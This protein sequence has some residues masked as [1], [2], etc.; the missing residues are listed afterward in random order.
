MGKPHNK[1]LRDIS[2]S[3]L[4]VI[5][6]SNGKTKT[7]VVGGRFQ[8]A[9]MTNANGRQYSN[10]LWERV[11]AD[12]GL[13]NTINRRQMLGTVEHPDNGE[14]N[15]TNVSHIITKLEKRGDE[16][17]GE[18]ELLDTP[19]GLI[20]QELARKGVPIGVSSRGKGR[21][22][23]ENGVEQIDP[24]SYILET[25]DLVYKPSTPGAYTSVCESVMTDSPLNESASQ[26]DRD[27]YL[28]SASKQ[29]QDLKDNVSFA[30]KSNLIDAQRKL[31]TVTESLRMMDGKADT[32]S[33]KKQVDG[34]LGQINTA[35]SNIED[36]E[37]IQTTL[38]EAAKSKDLNFMRQCLH[39]AENA[40]SFLLTRLGESQDD[41]VELTDITRRCEAATTLAEETLDKLREALS[42]LAEL[43]TE[44]ETL[45]ERYQAAVELAA[46][47][48][49][50]SKDSFAAPVQEADAPPYP[51]LVNME[52][53]RSTEDANLSDCNE[54]VVSINVPVSPS[55][56]V[57]ALSFKGTAAQSTDETNE[58]ITESEITRPDEVDLRASA[59]T[60]LE[61]GNHT[62]S[63]EMDLLGSLLESIG[64]Q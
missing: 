21:A 54:S 38:T 10:E 28:V 25:F 18:A 56:S 24:E 34:Y 39:E 3:T 53:L 57:N 58:M 37:E 55:P 59:S 14:T 16:I 12:E 45:K 15:L 63:P 47:L 9:N 62:N 4:S 41:S 20:M 64:G 48:T 7:M 30:N 35:I 50:K 33:I 43:N 52:T 5:S 32:S 1:E 29:L 44:N 60:I 36:S 6:E 13:T 31:I 17:Y 26:E 42:S 22:V 51:E 46:T 2:E 8:H 40:N 11:L 61:E 49:E 27:A 23:Y 19:D